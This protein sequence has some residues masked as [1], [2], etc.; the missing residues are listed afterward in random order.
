MYKGKPIKIAT[1]LSTDALKARRVWSEVFQALNENNFSPRA[2]YPAQ[3]RAIKLLH[4]KQK[5]N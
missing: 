3:L 4:N 5:L 1:D 2:L